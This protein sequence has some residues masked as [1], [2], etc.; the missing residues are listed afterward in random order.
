[1]GTVI[2]NVHPALRSCYH[3]VWRSTDLL[4]GQVLGVRLLGEHWA[5]ASV[6]GRPI[7]LIDRCAHRGMPLSA[8]AV[9]DGTVECP[10]H[11]YRYGAD[12]RCTLI[13]ALGPD[14]PAH[15]GL[16]LAPR[17]PSRSATASS[18]SLPTSQSRASSTFP[19]GT[20]PGSSSLRCLIRSGPPVPGR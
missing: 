2:D 20:A 8:G 18:G 14:S 19:S 1:M 10:Y 13:P 4:D 15:P 5:L 11:G 16:R 17:T 9:V 6:D 7:A 3:P 12:G